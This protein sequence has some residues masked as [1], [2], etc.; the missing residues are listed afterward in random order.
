MGAAEYQFT[1]NLEMFHGFQVIAVM[2]SLDGASGKYERRPDERVDE[3]R[4]AD[5]PVARRN[6][7]QH[8]VFLRSGASYR[9][10]YTAPYGGALL[11]IC[12][13]RI[14]L[15]NQLGDPWREEDFLKGRGIFP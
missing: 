7:T 13:F 14:D 3:G 9:I 6:H 4:L 2:D 5:A 1:V 11:E 12:E 15:S 10:R 8:T